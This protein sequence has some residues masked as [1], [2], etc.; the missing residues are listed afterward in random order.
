M[1]SPNPNVD[2]AIFASHCTKRKEPK[3]LQFES[4]REKSENSFFKSRLDSQKRE[5][6][7]PIR[8]KAQTFL[9]ALDPKGKKPKFLECE[10]KTDESFF[11][12]GSKLSSS[13]RANGISIRIQAQTFL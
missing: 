9:R 1:A 7:I 2:S 13:K 4:K 11:L 8:K 6:G 3:F 10:P 5:N 12:K